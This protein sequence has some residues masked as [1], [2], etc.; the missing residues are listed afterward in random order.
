MERERETDRT[1][2]SLSFCA[3]LCKRKEKKAILHGD[4]EHTEQKT[5]G[6]VEM[7]CYPSHSASGCRVT[8]DS[9]I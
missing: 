5:P 1:R 8:L 4:K 9:E 3:H 7:L 2:P 6:M